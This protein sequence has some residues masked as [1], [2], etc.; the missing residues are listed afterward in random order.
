VYSGRNG[1]AYWKQSRELM[2][3][4]FASARLVSDCSCRTKRDLLDDG[5]VDELETPGITT[6][7]LDVEYIKSRKVLDSA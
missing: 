5:L 7:L 3:K 6:Q 1:I 4:S 2:G